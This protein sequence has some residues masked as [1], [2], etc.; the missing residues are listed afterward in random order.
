MWIPLA[1]E[2][3]LLGDAL[4]GGPDLQNRG[5]QQVARVVKADLDYYLR[6]IKRDGLVQS[7]PSFKVY[8][9]SP[10]ATEAT[11]IYSAAGGPRR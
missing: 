1:G 8:V 6:A 5:A 2:D 3:N 11:R 9:D 4:L 10:L 7:L